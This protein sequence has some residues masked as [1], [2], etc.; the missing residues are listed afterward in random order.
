MSLSSGDS[1]GIHFE[2]LRRGMDIFF[3]NPFFGSGFGAS[4]LYLFDFF[5]GDKYSN[6][7]SLYITLVA[8]AGF[9]SFLLCLMILLTPLF[10]KDDKNTYKP[11]LLALIIFN[12]SYLSI[13]SPLF[14]IVL[15]FSWIG[16]DYK[17]YRYNYK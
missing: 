11:L 5:D 1:G 7:H 14:W 17:Y 16:L 3:D 10:M 9:L 13:L 8:E 2:L 12:M 15:S 6:Y 4:Y